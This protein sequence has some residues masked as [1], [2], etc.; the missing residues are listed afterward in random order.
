MEATAYSKETHSAT[1]T[2]N[3]QVYNG[4]K[5]RYRGAWARS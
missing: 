1:F 4:V 5:V 3:G 2:A